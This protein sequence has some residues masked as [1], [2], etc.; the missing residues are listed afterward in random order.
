M[1]NKRETSRV[2][3]LIALLVP[4]L[5]AVITT[6][7]IDKN[8]NSSYAV[9]EVSNKPLTLSYPSGIYESDL[10]IGINLD[11]EVSEDA[12][13]YFTIDGNDPDKDSYLYDGNAIYLGLIEDEIKVYPL[14]L[15]IYENEEY[16]EVYSYTY[17]IG[18]DAKSVLDLPIVSLT[19]ND[20]NLNDEETGIF[21]TKNLLERSSEW[22]REGRLTLIDT[23]GSTLIDENVGLQV[24]G[25]TSSFLDVKSLK[26]T[27]NKEYES[28]NNYVIYNGLTNN[29][30]K[31]TSNVNKFNKIKLR[32]GSQDRTITNI[33]ADLVSKLALEAGYDGV[34]EN[35]RAIMY[36][37]GEFYGIFD[38][39]P[40]YS[41]AYLA[42][43]FDLEDKDSIEK[44]EGTEMEALS[45]ASIRQYFDTDLNLEENQDALESV[46]DMDD[47]LMYFAINV[48][49]NNTDWPDNNFEMW[50]Y[51]GVEQ[52]GNKY[53]DGRFRFLIKDTDLV[54]YSS[55]LYQFFWGASSD[56]LES[57]LMNISKGT[58]SLFINVLRSSKYRSIFINN[59]CDLMN[60]TFE[61]SHVLSLVDES[62]NAI[63]NAN[64]I[65]FTSEYIKQLDGNIELLKEEVVKRNDDIAK[66]LNNYLDLD[67]KH[68]VNIK[69]NDG[70]YVKVSNLNIYQNE[71][72]SNSYYDD[73]KLVIKANAYKGYTFNYFKVN[74]KY[75]SQ[76]EITI[77]NKDIIDG[78][79]NV[80]VS[81]IRNDEEIAIKE[82]SAKSDSDWYKLINV[83]DHDVNA[84]KY[85]I[86]DDKNDLLKYQLPNK[87]L[88]PGETIIIN[89]KKNYYQVGNYIS[90][91]SL[92]HSETLYLYSKENNKIVDSVD[93]P[94]MS[95]KETY[96][97]IFETNNFV[98]YNNINNIRRE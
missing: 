12:K 4:F 76:D 91:F 72:Y 69:T 14:K 70:V 56:T 49:V 87:I 95:E 82:F 46:V 42:R 93:V 35:T 26:I 24:S 23:F 83:S 9:G 31:N 65:Y 33:K 98:F 2:Y 25:A 57:L 45:N 58:D 55:S 79:I 38:I 80:E 11:D 20:S 50:R 15:V 97:R 51:R 44:F 48:L 8:I 28:T 5:F 43:K 32:S 29:E 61:T 18:K 53:S 21:S 47:Y 34:Y 67:S 59:L 84:N 13:I 89:G 17:I 88:K 75:Y 92:N 94:I 52:E 71:E 81:A 22:I 41:S 62:Y 86:S 74:D 39:Q 36:L 19:T 85:Y 30:Y 96:G 66:V 78:K 37:N 60:T 10:Y 6:I 27:F 54:Y 1:E 73:T 90:N 64:S 68:E 77:T 7:I 40:N 63:S 16:S 3:F